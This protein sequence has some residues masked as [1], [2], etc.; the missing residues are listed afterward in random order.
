MRS[1]PAPM[2][3]DRLRC[4]VRW[5]FPDSDPY[6][7]AALDGGPGADLTGVLNEGRC[8]IVWFDEVGEITDEQFDRLLADARARMAEVF[9]IPREWLMVDVAD[10]DLTPEV[11]LER[12]RQLDA[13]GLPR[14][15]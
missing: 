9:D 15:G 1:Y 2:F 7:L 11:L 14:P 3:R 10:L 8:E 5:L 13:A 4:I 6:A 12:R